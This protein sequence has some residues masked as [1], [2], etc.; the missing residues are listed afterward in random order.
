MTFRKF[1][2]KF[3]DVFFI[4]AIVLVFCIA[5]FEEQLN[6]FKYAQIVRFF[7]LTLF[8]FALVGLFVKDKK[9]KNKD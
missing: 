9:R 4:P 3:S 2:K 7:L 1:L 8:I 6:V 5:I